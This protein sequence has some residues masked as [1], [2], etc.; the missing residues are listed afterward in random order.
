[1]A[2]VLLIAAPIIGIG[3][4]NALNSGDAIGEL[5]DLH[6]ELRDWEALSEEDDISRGGPGTRT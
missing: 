3:A 6:G 4:V 5:S 2:R 1:M